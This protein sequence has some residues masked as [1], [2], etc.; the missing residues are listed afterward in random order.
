MNES[1][2]EYLQ[3][4]SETQGKINALSYVVVMMAIVF[5]KIQSYKRLGA[6][7]RLTA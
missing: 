2:K 3:T 6:T 4:R 5:K 1:S 7:P